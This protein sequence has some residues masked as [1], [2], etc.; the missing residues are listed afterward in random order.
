MGLEYRMNQ[1]MQLGLEAW[2]LEQ[3]LQ[4]VEYFRRSVDLLPA[5][6]LEWAISMRLYGLALIR[7]QR[8]VE[9]TFVLE[10][11]DPILEQFGIAH[12][13]EHNLPSSN[14]WA[15]QPSLLAVFAH[16]DD[17]AFSSGGIL[18]HYAK[19][20]V[21]VELLCATRGEAGKITDPNLSI[22]D[23]GKHR[24]LE[25]RKA[26]SIMGISEPRFM[27]YHDSG[28]LERLQKDDP[29]ATINID[30][31]EMEQKII[32]VIKE[33]KPQ[34]MLTFDPHGGYNHPDHLSV[35]RAASAAFFSS[36]YLADAPQRLFFTAFP[37][38]TMREWIKQPSGPM[39]PGMTP[40]VFGVSADT[41]AVKFDGSA[42][43]EQKLAALDAHGS[44]TGQNS[45]MGQLPPAQKATMLERIKTET[46][47]L[48]GTRGAIQNY[49][50]KGFFDGLGL[51]VD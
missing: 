28:R 7:V 10:R 49:P 45:R 12:F 17:E 19:L 48:G 15:M 27:D 26:C 22:S 35:Y 34:V 5:H 3:D 2:K 51:G 25:L 8:E 33:T 40:E 38:E 14:L 13:D 47:A 42:Y 50:L 9:G 21:R 1:E 11:S 24:E 36:G 20:G 31:L 43:T 46:F 16:P 4:A 23:L 18:S 6:S 29:L 32:E 44:Q 37:L 39:T 41:I 30:Y